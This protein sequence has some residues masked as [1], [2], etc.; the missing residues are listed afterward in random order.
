[1]KIKKGIID[2][3]KKIVLFAVLFLFSIILAG[4][5][6][7][8]L[9]DTSGTGNITAEV[10]TSTLFNITIKNI[11]DSSYANFTQ[12]NLKFPSG[13]AINM[14]ANGTTAQGTFS[15]NSQTLSWT[16]GTN[17]NDYVILNNTL[18]YFWVYATPS[19]LGDF[20]ITIT[21][22]DTHSNT[23][24]SNVSVTVQDTASPSLTFVS[25]TPSEGVT[26]PRNYIYANLSVTDFAIDAITI[27]LYNSTGLQSSSTP[28]SAPS[29][30]QSYTA[31]TNFTELAD[32]IYYLNATANDSSGNLGISSTKIINIS[33]SSSTCVPNWTYSD[34][35]NCIDGFQIR[36]ATDSNN[37]G[38]TTGR[39]SLNQSCTT[40]CIPN[41]TY[42]SWSNC[43]NGY[44]IRTATD[45]NNCNDN[46]GVGS[47]NQTCSYSQ[48]SGGTNWVFLSIIIGVIIVI[49]VV[50]IVIIYLLNS[51][52]P[53]E[54][55]AQNNLRNYP[56]YP[57]NSGN[58]FHY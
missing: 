39:S 55:N 51:S 56:T 43:V 17:P 53:E 16:N 1:M 27:Y 15:N 3:D 18:Q 31:G 12:V 7:G 21:S 52:R 33:F 30:A 34:W 32:G 29:G 54:Q 23:N 38:V 44:Q 10:N 4:F 28:A 11:G 36:T 37:C 41:W 2:T 47:L 42:S 40:A 6:S 26:I 25:P 24:S 48:N 14:S 19:A 58:D 45:S 5:I 8:D 9:L 49:A 50:V 57:G 22:L 20:N 13:F 46:S 35:G